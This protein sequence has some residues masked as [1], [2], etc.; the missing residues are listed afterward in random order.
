M[1]ATETPAAILV[2]WPEAPSV[3][4]PRRLDE[5][6][7]ATIAILAEARATL[8]KVKAAEL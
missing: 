1:Q 8:A 2:C 5:L 4:D 6:A 3:T 7:S